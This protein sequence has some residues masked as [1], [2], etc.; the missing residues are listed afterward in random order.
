MYDEL[1]V[2]AAAVDYGTSG[3]WNVSVYTTRRTAG[4]NNNATAF[5]KKT[6][7]A[8]VHLRPRINSRRRVLYA[9]ETDANA[10]RLRA[11]LPF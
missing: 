3:G 6:I 11:R 8:A 10:V 1:G 4:S 2:L 7:A 5:W 9:K